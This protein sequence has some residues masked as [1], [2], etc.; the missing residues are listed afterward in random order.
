MEVRKMK[1]I[2]KIVEIKNGRKWETERVITEES[3]VYK[4][5]AHDLIAKKIHACTYIKSIK[6]ICNYDGTQTIT[7]TYNNDCRSIYTVEN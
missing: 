2:N 5:L 4:S 7:V 3:E 6:R 1:E